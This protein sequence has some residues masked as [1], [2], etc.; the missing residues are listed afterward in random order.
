MI[1]YVLPQFYESGYK[2]IQVLHTLLPAFI[3]LGF[4]FCVLLPTKC[5]PV[6]LSYSALH[7][8]FV[9]NYAIVIAIVVVNL[10]LLQL[11][12]RFPGHVLV[13]YKQLIASLSLFVAMFAQ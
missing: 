4:L 2:Q 5:S 10:Q 6:W 7:Y 13:L 3:A 12:C 1:T 11:D 9:L 8:C